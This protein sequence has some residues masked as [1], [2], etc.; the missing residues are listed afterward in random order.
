MR[1]S[2]TGTLTDKY[3]TNNL[4]DLNTCSEGSQNPQKPCE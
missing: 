2:T 4:T 1:K 3:F